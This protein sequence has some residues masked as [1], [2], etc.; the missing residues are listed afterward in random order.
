MIV[1]IGGVLCASTWAYYKIFTSPAEADAP[2][3]PAPPLP[4]EE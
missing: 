1:S 2:L 4:D 3:N